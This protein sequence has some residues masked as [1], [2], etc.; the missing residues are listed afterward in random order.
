MAKRIEDMT[1]EEVLAEF[2][3]GAVQFRVPRRPR[4]LVP[5]TLRVHPDLVRQLGE[6]AKR[7]NISGHTTLARILL[8]TAMSRPRES[9]AD[10]IA[11]AVVTRLKSRRLAGRR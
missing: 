11:D 2:R 9:L 7:R 8:E 4:K 10:Q 5:L 6:E 3:G 1:L